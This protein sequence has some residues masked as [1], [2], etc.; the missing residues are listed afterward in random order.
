MVRSLHSL[1]YQCILYAWI[2]AQVKAAT[3]PHQL[4]DFQNLGYVHL[5]RTTDEGVMNE[6]AFCLMR[7]LADKRTDGAN[8]HASCSCMVV[9]AAVS[10]GQGDGRRFGRPE[11]SASWDIS[12]RNFCLELPST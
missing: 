11:H 5:P 7:I 10:T 3:G 1:S 2:C 6:E 9:G 12:S 8:K 4:I